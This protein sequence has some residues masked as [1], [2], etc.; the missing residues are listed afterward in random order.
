MIVTIPNHL[1]KL[2]YPDYRIDDEVN[3]EVEIEVD[4]AQTAFYLQPIT[5][6]ILCSKG[7]YRFSKEQRAKMRRKIVFEEV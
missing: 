3:L 4:D 1:L 7:R 2:V 6:G 5:Q